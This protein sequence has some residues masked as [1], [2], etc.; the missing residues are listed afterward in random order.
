VAIERLLERSAMLF[1]GEA[2]DR[3]G[4]IPPL[5]RGRLVEA[6]GELAAVAA[7]LSAPEPLLLGTEPFRR[8]DASPV[9][10]ALKESTGLVLEVL[11]P[12]EEGLLTLLGV[13][14]GRPPAGLL[15]VVDIGGGSTEVIMAGPA[16]AA[17][18]S[19][20]ALGS[21][22]LDAE[23]PHADPPSETELDALRAAA[24]RAVAGMGGLRPSGP[25]TPEAKPGMVLVGGSATNLAKLATGRTEMQLGSAEL[26]A[27]ES[28]LLGSPSSELALRHGLHPRRARVLPAGLAILEAIM[29]SAGVGRATVSDASLRDGAILARAIAGP[30]WRARLA[31]LAGGTEPGE[32]PGPLAS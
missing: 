13:T 22:R 5:E 4:S 11:S 26:R 30:A 20:L 1:I 32:R 16:T 25:P 23:V 6:V 18:V 9:A 10:R 3:Q 31:G 17:T 2:I 15:L 19:T 27:A 12:Q 8:T 24:H 14:A 21:A 7:A 28:L 29:A